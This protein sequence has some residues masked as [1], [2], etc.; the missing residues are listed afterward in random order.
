LATRSWSDI[1]LQHALLDLLVQLG[2]D[3]RFQREWQAASLQEA[4]TSL[5]LQL[6]VNWRS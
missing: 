5:R 3:L 2:F 1:R 4:W 6:Q